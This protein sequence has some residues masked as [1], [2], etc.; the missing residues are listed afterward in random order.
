MGANIEWSNRAIQDAQR[1][2]PG[3]RRRVI[4]AI[5]RFAS[6]GAGDVRRLRG[7]NREWRLRVGKWRVLLAYNLGDATVLILRVLPRAE[8]YR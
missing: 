1:L 3:V 8:A 7:R 5:E 2:D 6:T 4:E